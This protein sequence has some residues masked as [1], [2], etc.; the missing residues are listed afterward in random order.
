MLR[1]PQ[2]QE[3]VWCKTLST[4]KDAIIARVAMGVSELYDRAARALTGLFSLTCT[5][6][7]ATM[8]KEREGKKGRGV[9]GKPLNA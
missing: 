8:M 6:K 1:G 2:A 3:I 5:E 7:Q 9:F 4:G